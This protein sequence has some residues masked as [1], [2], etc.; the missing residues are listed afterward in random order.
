MATQSPVSRIQEHD[1]RQEMGL[2][3]LVLAQVLCVVGSS[4][5]GVAAKLGRAH[6]VFWIVAMLLFY[7]PLAVV[8]IYLNRLMPLEGGL[9][10]WAK[11]GFGEMAGFLTA[12]NLWVYA[13]VC[14][15][16]IIFVIPT[17]IY[18]MLGPPAAWL[19][20]SKP[21]TLA[22][23]GAVMAA[24]T[25]VAIRGLNLGKWLHNTGSVM[26]LL[27]YAILLALPVWALWRGSLH[28]FE[29]IPWQWP[30][31]DLFSLAVFGQMSVGGLSGFEYVA[32]M[33]GECRSAART[34]GQSVIISAPIISL[35]FILGTSVVLAFIGGQPINVV[36]PIPQTM[37]AA[38]GTPIPQTM[39]AAMGTTGAA[40]LAAPFAIF[41][42]IARAIA[43]S[44]LIFTGLTR[45]PMTAGWDNLVPRW[46]SQLHPRWR[47]PQNSILFV[48]AL[49][50]GLILMSMM[51]V[52]EQEA[53]Q[54]LLVASDV[55]YAITYAA[56]FLIPLVGT[57]VLRGRLPVWL[58]I[59]AAAGLATSLISMFIAVYPIVDV[60]SR[61]AY[62]TKICSLVVV[63]NMIGIL[64]YRWGS[65]RSAARQ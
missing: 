15:G 27:A 22:I 56:L 50:M 17:D 21:A 5:V 62:A 54:S 8:V 39:R 35:M 55:H 58:K 23:T 1:L 19:P 34:V 48:A 6:V 33:A 7:L 36:G 64:I 2:G 57:R 49:V 13:V 45:L 31:L 38:M 60:V 51:G 28:H 40:G 20:A 24:I 9:Y 3:D 47:T 14:V 65:T 26:I 59:A 25:L 61:G 52:R 53:S 12:W 16:A 46:F 37:R 44:S 4:W 43:S 30:K 11:A 29:A 63:S 32:I 18:Y 10:Q 41:L 42:L